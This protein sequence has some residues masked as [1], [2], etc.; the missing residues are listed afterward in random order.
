MASRQAFANYLQS[1]GFPIEL[2]HALANQGIEN[3]A[4]FIGMTESDVD[5]LCTNIRK[6]GGLIPNPAHAND[7][8]AP[9]RI[10]DPGVAVGRVY[11]ERL[12][13][14]AYYYSYLVIVGRNFVANHADVEQLV[15]LWKYKKNL[16]NVKKN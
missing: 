10:I 2:R 4:C 5:D 9:E 13:Q 8:T 15:R 7:A 12:K 1:I 11:Q 6:P 3:I 14:I 16:E